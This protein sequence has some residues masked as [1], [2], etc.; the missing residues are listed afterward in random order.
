MN[1]SNIK[2]LYNFLKQHELI[3]SS[4]NEDTAIDYLK[5]LGQ[6]LSS[7]EE[8]ISGF[9]IDVLDT[10]LQSKLFYV[11]ST[12]KLLSYPE[13]DSFPSSLNINDINIIELE[14]NEIVINTD[15]HNYILQAPD[16][17]G[18]DIVNDALYSS[19]AE[20]FDDEKLDDIFGEED[21]DDEDEEL[22][23]PE[24]PIEEKTKVSP[25]TEDVQNDNIS[26]TTG[27]NSSN[28]TSNEGID[29][30]K[31]I[32]NDS[33]E[34]SNNKIKPT[35][36]SKAIKGK[37]NKPTLYVLIGVGVLLVALVAGFL[38]NNVV[39]NSRDKQKADDL[40]N[41]FN[42]LDV[43]FDQAKEYQE[44]GRDGVTVEDWQALEERATEI[45]DELISYEP[46]EN[47][48]DFYQALYFYNDSLLKAIYYGKNYV[49]TGNAL[50][51]SSLDTNMNITERYRIAALDQLGLAYPELVDQITDEDYHNG[52]VATYPAKDEVDALEAEANSKPS[53]GAANR[54]NSKSSNEALENS[55]KSRE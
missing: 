55:H 4:I 16:S 22:I 53:E 8:L 52:S 47:L 54:E 18:A 26:F 33:S 51:Q 46:S 12:Q 15:S 41:Y 36:D 3:Q 38:I 2:E 39:S 31:K 35:S 21:F 32:L 29:K 40:V 27:N 48:E 13:T 44:K 7:N 50:Q 5:K 30:N 10:S 42:E 14:A 28:V 45:D 19:F 25:K 43:L 23:I 11:T 24:E 1:D 37:L 49:S 6:K 17:N 20:F 9:F 34:S